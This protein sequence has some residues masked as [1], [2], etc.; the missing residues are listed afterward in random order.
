MDDL[1]EVAVHL[2]R[3]THDHRRLQLDLV[4]TAGPLS[5]LR[6]RAQAR[7]L[8]GL[9]EALPN[10][11]DG[12]LVLTPGE[13]GQEVL[14][15][16]SRIPDLEEGHRRGPDDRRAVRLGGGACGRTLVLA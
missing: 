7:A 9:R 8:A 13:F 1:L 15:V 11:L 12:G 4:A 2:V 14:R 6:Q 3:R 5:E 10:G 16:D